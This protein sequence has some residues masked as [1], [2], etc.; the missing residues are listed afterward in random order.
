MDMTLDKWNAERAKLR[1]AFSK[2]EI[3]NASRQELEW[4]LFV[5]A[6][7]PHDPRFIAAADSRQIE[8][9]RETKAFSIIIR[10]LLIV[11]LGEELHAKSHKIS[12]LAL[13]VA[14]GSVVVSLV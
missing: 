7:T 11:Q 8:H 4:Y 10:H 3:V 1:T 5:L 2:G 14:I 12:C 9:R 13:W 6:N